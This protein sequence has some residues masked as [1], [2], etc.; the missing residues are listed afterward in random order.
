MTKMGVR[1][2]R[3]RVVELGKMEKSRRE[4]NS[5]VPLGKN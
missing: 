2:G 4:K 1:M 5:R 3:K